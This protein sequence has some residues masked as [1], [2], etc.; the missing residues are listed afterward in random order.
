MVI[1]YR[2]SS[3]PSKLPLSLGEVN[4]KQGVNEKISYLPDTLNITETEQ[5]VEHSHTPG[6]SRQGPAKEPC[7]KLTSIPERA[8]ANTQEEV[9]AHLR[10]EQLHQRSAAS[11]PTK[12]VNAC[13][14]FQILKTRCHLSVTWIHPVNR[15]LAVKKGELL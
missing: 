13:E 9:L 14:F 15:R 5:V 3:L 4:Y 7:R 6:N 10:M 1:L 11:D 8:T 12:A 2:R